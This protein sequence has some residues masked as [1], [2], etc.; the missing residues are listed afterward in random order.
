MPWTFRPNCKKSCRLARWVFCKALNNK[1]LCKTAPAELR[2]F[3][4]FGRNLY[5]SGV[6]LH[7][8]HGGEAGEEGDSAVDEL[9]PD[10]AALAFGKERD[11]CMT[12]L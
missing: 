4:Q 9:G 7:E 8:Q 12:V 2:E 10:E 5:S 11:G 1:G 3:Q 6:K